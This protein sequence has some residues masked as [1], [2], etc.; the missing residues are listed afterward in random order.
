[1]N[2]NQ[3]RH[4]ELLRRLQDLE[5]QGRS[6]YDENQDDYLE[7]LDYRATVQEHVFWKNRRQFGLLMENFINGIID[8]EEFSDKFCG[9]YRKTLDAFDAFETDLEKLEDFQPDLRSSGFGSIISA[10]RR[11]CEAFEPDSTFVELN[12]VRE[13]DDYTEEQLK[14]LI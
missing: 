9:I 3:I 5:K 7:L 1:M 6:L 11:D 12:I 10:L 4:L 13:S 2:Y 14:D 8:G